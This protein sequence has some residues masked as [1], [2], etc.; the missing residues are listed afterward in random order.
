MPQGSDSPRSGAIAETARI[1]S[2]YVSHSH[3]P[4][5][6]IDVFIRRAHAAVANLG[7]EPRNEAES[8]AI[9]KPTAAQISNSIRPDGLISFINGRTYASL[10]RHLTAHGLGPHSYRQRYGL[11]K[12]YPMVAPSYAAL[13]SELAKRIGLGRPGRMETRR[14]GKQDTA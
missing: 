3:V 13:R 4:A 11:P 10:K 8:A 1:V 6:E 9:R 5:A 14:S 12:D 7:N 2:A